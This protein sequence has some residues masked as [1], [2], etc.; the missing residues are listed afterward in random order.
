MGSLGGVLWQTLLTKMRSCGTGVQKLKH[1]FQIEDPFLGVPK[2]RLVSILGYMR[3]TPMLEKCVKSTAIHD[4]T[5]CPSAC[6]CAGRCHTSKPN[7]GTVI[8]RV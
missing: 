5:S 1:G 2:M 4:S 6:G 8:S 3:G 7:V